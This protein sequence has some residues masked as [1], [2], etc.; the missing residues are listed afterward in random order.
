MTP[1]WQPTVSPNDLAI[2]RPGISSFLNQTLGGPILLPVESTYRLPFIG[3]TLPPAFSTLNF[4]EGSSGL[5]S[6]DK[7]IAI[8]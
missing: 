3:S 2:A 7:G 6:L 4:S 8:Q 1:T 5:W